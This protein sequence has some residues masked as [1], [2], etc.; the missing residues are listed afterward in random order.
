V[1]RVGGLAP[2]QGTAGFLKRKDYVE[3]F[4]EDVALQV[5]GAGGREAARA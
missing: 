3:Q 4:G 2:P 1:P 5:M